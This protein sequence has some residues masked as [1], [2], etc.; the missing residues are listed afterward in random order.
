MKPE[1]RAARALGFVD[2]E[3]RAIVPPI[4][5]STTFERE[6]DGTYPAGFEYTRAVIAQQD[7][8]A[9]E[10]VARCRSVAETHRVAAQASRVAGEPMESSTVRRL[11]TACGGFRSDPAYGGHLRM[12]PNRTPF[13]A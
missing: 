2:P 11:R 13:P 3:T 6:V 5:M 8:A 1:T 4:Q 10:L 12:D 7:R 9:G